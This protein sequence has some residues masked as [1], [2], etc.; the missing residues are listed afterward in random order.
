MMS[1]SLQ[2]RS[3]RRRSRVALS[4][5]MLCATNYVS[6]FHHSINTIHPIRSSRTSLAA[7]TTS[8]GGSSPGGSLPSLPNIRAAVI[9]PGFLTGRDEFIPLAES[10]NA[11]G[12]PTVVVPMPNWHWLP[13]LGGRSMRPMLERIDFTVRHLAGVAGNLGDFE[14]V[15]SES[16]DNTTSVN[17][18]LLIPDFSYSLIDLYQDFRNNPGGVLNVGGSA[19][20]EDYP[21]WIPKGTFQQAPEPAGKV[22]LIGHSAGGWICRA[23]LSQRNYGGKAYQGQ[24]VVHSLITLGSP[25]S[26]APGAAFKGVEWV[27]RE[28]LEGVRALAVGGTGYK[29]D[30]SGQLTQ[31]AYSFCCPDGSDGKSYD[32]DGVTPIQSALAMKDHSPNTDTLVLDDVGHFC[33]SDVF[34]GETVAPELSAFHREGRPWYG[35]EEVIEKWAGWL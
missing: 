1:P 11:K 6:A 14:R 22:A 24:E 25:H 10:L 12:I 23:Y 35:D 26:N 16:L 4:F 30:S 19:E 27:N 21:L 7:Y 20:V 34:G 9:V 18:Q 28:P 2:N 31:N 33:W 3:R 32:G 15:T 8:T 17:P 5:R 29:G 13:C